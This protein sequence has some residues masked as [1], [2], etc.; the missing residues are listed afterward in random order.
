ML[1]GSIQ[2]NQQSTFTMET[3]PSGNGPFDTRE[4]VKQ[5]D[6]LEQM[7]SR[8][9]RFMTMSAAM[10]GLTHVYPGDSAAN[11][12]KIQADIAQQFAEILYLSEECVGNF[13]RDIL[14][15][16]FNRV[17][18]ASALMKQNLGGIL[19]D[20]RAALS[21]FN[22]APANLARETQAAGLKKRIE[23]LKELGNNDLLDA[24]KLEVIIKKFSEI[25][26]N[27]D[28]K[29]RAASELITQSGQAGQLGE[30]DLNEAASDQRDLI[31]IR[32][33]DFR[34]G[35]GK[36]RANFQKHLNT[37]SGTASTLWTDS[38]KDYVPASMACPV[39]GK[40]RF[41]AVRTSTAAALTTINTAISAVVTPITSLITSLKAQTDPVRTQSDTLEA[42]CERVGFWTR[43]NRAPNPSNGPN[44]PVSRLPE[45]RSLIADTLSVITTTPN[46][47]STADAA[48]EVSTRATLTAELEVEYK[49]IEL[50]SLSLSEREDFDAIKLLIAQGTSS[51]DSLRT[52]FAS[53]AL[54]GLNVFYT[55]TAT[56]YGIPF[57]FEF[58]LDI[59]KFKLFAA[60]FNVS[61]GPNVKSTFDSARD[62]DQISLNL[63]L[64]LSRTST[65]LLSLL[66]RSNIFPTIQKGLSFQN[67]VL[68]PIVDSLLKVNTDVAATV[69]SE[70]STG[71]D[72]LQSRLDV[73]I[74][75]FKREADRIPAIRTDLK[76]F[77]TSA[78]LNVLR[79]TSLY[80]NL[81]S[82]T[83]ATKL[84]L[85]ALVTGVSTLPDIAIPN[86]Y[87]SP[88]PPALG[89]ANYRSFVIQFNNTNCYN[90][91][92]ANTKEAADALVQVYHCP[93]DIRSAVALT[94]IPRFFLSTVWRSNPNATLSNGVTALPATN[95]Q[96]INHSTS[97]AVDGTDAAK[98][99]LRIVDG[100]VSPFKEYSV[101]LKSASTSLFLLEV[102]VPVLKLP[103]RDLLD[104]NPH[105][106]LAQY[107]GY[108]GL[109]LNL[110]TF[111]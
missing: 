9:N 64:R 61:P 20:S 28:I 49:Q 86:S 43:V 83:A 25:K 34:I 85:K 68:R 12:T 82:F 55:A 16:A 5:G 69:V 4:L 38:T 23:E 110:T 33:E 80:S 41:E 98:R 73:A 60:K 78:K 30:A 99:Y 67:T 107:R 102:K 111:V 31:A 106:D 74:A 44:P 65:Y 95:P 79:I 100:D 8:A 87:T 45:I 54:E 2:H 108:S 21:G 18:D 15:N 66:Q 29:T 37:I 40:A 88:A 35:F 52:N 59:E 75:D 57:Q 48:L 58:P 10:T 63:N 39:D 94:A 62:L 105:V 90:I 42:I 46:L 26:N 53:Q 92:N 72:A 101:A 70:F 24:N 50:N 19:S 13:T 77:E 36:V 76:K 1:F 11:V 47:F 51:A 89:P 22:T 3:P 84:K 71:Y 96:L 6:C 27:V 103:V 93:I 14:Q 104:N 91:S 17:A 32:R 109:H 7:A 56:S 97:P 81:D